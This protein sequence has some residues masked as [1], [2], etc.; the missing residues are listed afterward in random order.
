MRVGASAGGVEL[1]A[2]E[3]EGVLAV[4][5]A[6]ALVGVLGVAGAAVGVGGVAVVA[7]LGAGGAGEAGGAG[8]KLVRMLVRVRGG[9]GG[10]YALGCAGSDVVGETGA[11]AGGSHEDGG[12]DHVEG[13]GVDWDGGVAEADVGIASS[14]ESVIH[15]LTTL[16]S[17]SLIQIPDDFG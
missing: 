7:D 9:K 17:V 11:V 5:A 3:G 6:V 10:T 15:D 2:D 8:G 16:G 12:L 1:G 13:R 4:D 14:A